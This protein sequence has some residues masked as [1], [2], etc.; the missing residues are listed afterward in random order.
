[1]TDENINAEE[2]VVEVVAEDEVVATDEDTSTEEA[3][4]TETV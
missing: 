4:E 2:Q 1:M 3:T